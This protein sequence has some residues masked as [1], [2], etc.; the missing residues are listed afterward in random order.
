[1]VHNDRDP[2]Q[3]GDEVVHARPLAQLRR[4]ATVGELRIHVEVSS[5]D[6]LTIDYARDLRDQLI[7]CIDTGDLLE[8]P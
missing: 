7:R 6:A 2:A 8:H 4:L 5:D 1:M 3:Q